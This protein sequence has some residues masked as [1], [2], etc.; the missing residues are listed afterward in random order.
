MTLFVVFLVM[1]LVELYVIIKVGGWIGILPTI[2]LLILDSL[3]GTWLI[4][5]EGTRAWRALEAQLRT[6]RMPH[7]ELADGALIVL[8]GALMLSPGF[9]TDVFGVLLVLPLTRPLFRRLLASYAAGRVSAYATGGMPRTGDMPPRG[10]PD[11]VQGDV[12]D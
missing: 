6:G 10:G 8:G 5:R 9:V 7:K 12:I 11:V 2:G 4:R 3:L 1:P